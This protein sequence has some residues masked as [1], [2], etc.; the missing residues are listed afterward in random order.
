MRVGFWYSSVNAY[1]DGQLQLDGNDA[2]DLRFTTRSRYDPL[3]MG[4]EIGATLLRLTQGKSLSLSL[5]IP[6]AFALLLP[7]Y[8]LWH[9]LNLAKRK[10]PVVNLA[11]SLAISLAIVPV[12]LLWSTVFG[13]H[14]HFARYSGCSARGSLTLLPGWLKAA[15]GPP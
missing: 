4:R 13:L 5:V 3:L 8:L 15:A 6:L 10:D 14:W 1:G 11:F 9:S 7:G 12:C 2:G